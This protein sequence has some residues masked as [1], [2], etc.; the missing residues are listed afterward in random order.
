MRKKIKSKFRVAI[1]TLLLSSGFGTL[2]FVDSV[3]ADV[4]TSTVAGGEDGVAFSP[5]GSH[6]YFPNAPRSLIDLD[7]SSGSRRVIGDLESSG[8]CK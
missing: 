1:T 8:G 6:V 7:L 2:N 4:V 5:D 3:S